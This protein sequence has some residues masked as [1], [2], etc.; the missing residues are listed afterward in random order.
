MNRAQLVHRCLPRQI[1]RSNHPDAIS[2]PTNKCVLCGNAH[3]LWACD[4]SKKL[5]TIDRYEKVKE[6]KMCLCL[7][8]GHP[9]KYCK[10]KDCGIDGCRKRHNRLLHRSEL[11]SKQATKATETVEANASAGLNNFGILLE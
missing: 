9:V 10:M 2:K 6:A 1:R 3:E 4:A 7:C 5:N 11:S 8:S